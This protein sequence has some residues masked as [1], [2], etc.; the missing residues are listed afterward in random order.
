MTI[1]PSQ[2]EMTGALIVA[3][4]VVAIAAAIIGSLVR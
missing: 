2:L 4:L 1:D 3:A